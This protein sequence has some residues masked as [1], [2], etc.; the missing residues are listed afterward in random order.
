MPSGV[1]CPP[2]MSSRPSMGNWKSC[3]ETRE[4]TSIPTKP[5]SSNWAWPSRNWNLAA[6]AALP[7]PFKMPWITSTLS[8]RL[9]SNPNH[10]LLLR[11]NILDKCQIIGQHSDRKIQSISV[12]LST[13]HLLHGEAHLEFLVPVFT[14]APLIVF[15]N[16]FHR[17]FLPVVGHRMIAIPSRFKQV[18]LRI[19]PAQYDQP[20]CLLGSVH[21]VHRLSDLA[22][23]R[24][25]VPGPVGGPGC[26]RQ[27]FDLPPHGRI[28]IRRDREAPARL[29]VMIDHLGLIRCAVTA[30]IDPLPFRQ[31]GLTALREFQYPGARAFIASPELGS[32]ADTAHVTQQ[33]HV[34]FDLV[35]SPGRF[36]LLRLDLGGVYI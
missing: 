17:S 19:G 12:E 9:A 16:H 28:Q 27:V 30:E 34:A 15:P 18:R 25:A 1:P 3:A 20:E 29:T 8:S 21:R 5:S 7:L 36:C 13:R 32:H 6:G 33:R 2:P 10:E 26:L 31:R 24:N 23:G 35:V 11:H 4:A 14:V 22:I